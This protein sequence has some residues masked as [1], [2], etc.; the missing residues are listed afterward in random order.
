MHTNRAISVLFTFIYLENPLSSCFRNRYVCAHEFIR[1]LVNV[2]AKSQKNLGYFWQQT[3]SP[4]RFCC[5]YCIRCRWRMDDSR[6]IKIYRPFTVRF[7]MC[8]RYWMSRQKIR[9]PI[10]Q[11]MIFT[12][13]L[14]VNGD[15]EAGAVILFEAGRGADDGH[16]T[17]LHKFF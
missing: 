9:C 17:P 16:D 11:E 3:T 8:R 13:C 1:E 2:K 14:A 4:I 12:L 7:P 6:W 15:T 5:I 10:S